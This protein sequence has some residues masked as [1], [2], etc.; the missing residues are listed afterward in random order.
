MTKKIGRR[1]FIKKS[2]KI[3]LSTALG[4]SVFYQ[5]IG[6]SGC[7]PGE[8]VD[9]AVVAGSD[10]T[11]STIKAVE[12]LGG[13][14]KFVPKNSKVAILP[15][16]QSRHP[17]SYTKPEIV[18]TVI[19]MCK[20]AGA[21]EVNCLSWLTRKHWESTGLAQ[22][23]E[24]EGANLKLI[25]NSDES[26]FKTI[27]IPN[28]KELKEAQIMK[29]LYTNDVFINMPITKDHA[30]NKFTGTMK[31]LMGLNYR[32]N[33]RS[34]HKEDW[35][36]NQNSIEFL[37][38]CIADLNTVVEPTLCIVDAT[39]FITTNGPFGP[40]KLIKPQKIVAGVDRVAA[41]AYCTT[42]WG[43]EAKDIVMINRGYEH[44]LGEID[45]AKVK[46]KEI[47]A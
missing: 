22:A 20:E 30:G 9:M 40:G 31:N 34:F 6:H 10:Y 26:L 27:P 38:Q 42:L 45:L 32:M 36:T 28:G 44:K 11:K 7:A 15:N 46:I 13:I 29:E 2:A 14:E 25:D 3:S 5:L 41:D 24:E 33:N 23:V 47:K 16:T 12:I 35:A 43:L 19:R 37:D 18:R 17:G 8:K 1:D 39:E 4:S 21:A